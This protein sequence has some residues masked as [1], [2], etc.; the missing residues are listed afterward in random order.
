[1]KYFLRSSISNNLYAINQSADPEKQEKPYNVQ[2]LE[3]CDMYPDENFMLIT[4]NGDSHKM[5]QKV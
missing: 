1:M 5:V 2:Q 4:L 3:E